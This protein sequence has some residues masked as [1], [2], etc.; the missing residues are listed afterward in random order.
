MQGELPFRDDCVML[1]PTPSECLFFAV[2]PSA[3]DATHVARFRDRFVRDNGL[4]GTLIRTNRLH[5]SLHGIGEYRRAPAEIVHAARLAGDAV[6]AHPV[7][8]SLRTI[9]SFGPSPSRKGRRAPLVLL[10]E[11]SA[12]AA[13]HGTLGASM[14]GQG[15]KAADRF[16]PHMTLLYGPIT[17]P[18]RPIDDIRLTFTS[19]A[20]IR[21]HRGLSRYDIE[22]S[23]SLGL[24]PFGAVNPVTRL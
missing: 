10:D 19:F 22:G 18:P 14:R 1:K 21:S 16:V 15:L 6:R 11:G 4:C 9:Q 7:A 23:W 24:Q 20:L 8:V 12:L 3:Q 5:I 13:L 2:F 17:V